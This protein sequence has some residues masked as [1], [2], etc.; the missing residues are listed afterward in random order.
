MEAVKI[1]FTLIHD[2]DMT[3]MHPPFK[4]LEGSMSLTALKM[5][6]ILIAKEG[7]KCTAIVVHSVELWAFILCKLLT[8]ADL[9]WLVWKA[10]SLP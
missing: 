5:V 7:K 8:Q 1:I 6:L 3:A 10:P 2:L 9:F 4:T